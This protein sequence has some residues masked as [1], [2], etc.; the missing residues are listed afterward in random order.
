MVARDGSRGRAALRFTKFLPQVLATLPLFTEGA[1]YG[2]PPRP[3]VRSEGPSA[4]FRKESFSLE[5]LAVIRAAQYYMAGSNGDFRIEDDRG[6]IIADD[7][8]IRQRCKTT[9]MP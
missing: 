7:R 1:Q 9:R 4:L 3:K 2:V 6:R 5:P 8:E